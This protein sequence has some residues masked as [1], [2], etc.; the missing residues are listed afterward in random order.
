M[1][2]LRPDACRIFPFVPDLTVQASRRGNNLLQLHPSACPWQWPNSD[3]Q[4]QE[5][6]DLLNVNQQHLAMDREL[7]AQWEGEPREADFYAWLEQAMDEASL[8]PRAPA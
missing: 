1:H 6:L 5:I 2:G 7:L 3:G 8:E 4:R